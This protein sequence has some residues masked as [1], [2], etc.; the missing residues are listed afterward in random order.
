MNL[1]S[2]IKTK[3]TPKADENVDLEIEQA[4]AEE[5]QEKQE[6][7]ETKAAIKLM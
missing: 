7:K 1:D 3:D 4:N 6:Q 5:K 2:D